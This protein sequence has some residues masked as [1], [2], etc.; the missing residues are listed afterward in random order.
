MSFIV[1]ENGSRVGVFGQAGQDGAAEIGLSVLAAVPPVGSDRLIDLIDVKRAAC[2]DD[3]FGNQ[4]LELS[5]LDQRPTGLLGSGQRR[6]FF[7]RRVFRMLFGARRFGVEL[8]RCFGDVWDWLAGAGLPPG[9]KV[10]ALFGLLGG[11]GSL[12]GLLFLLSSGFWR[13]VIKQI[14]GIGGP[15]RIKLVG[16]RGTRGPACAGAASSLSSVV[17]PARFSARG[18]PVLVLVATREQMVNVGGEGPVAIGVA[19][20]Q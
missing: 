7:R 9:F 2:G 8:M 18:S 6:R 12:G 11:R 4:Q 5:E 19:G 10:G 3:R 16:G 13:L 17:V 14:T 20:E 1:L 15:G